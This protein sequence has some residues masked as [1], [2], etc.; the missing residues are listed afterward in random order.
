MVGIE[1]DHFDSTRENHLPV[2]I[3]T[4]MNAGKGSRLVNGFD[5]FSEQL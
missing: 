2:S 5:D 3:G 4:N 1:I